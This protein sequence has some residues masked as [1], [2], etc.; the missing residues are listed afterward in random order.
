MKKLIL[1]LLFFPALLQAAPVNIRLVI[2]ESPTSMNC[3]DA[4]YYFNSARS[5]IKKHTGA[6]TRI[7]YRK[8]I[9]N[10]H[11]PAPVVDNRILL[12]RRV[13]PKLRY[14]RRTIGIAIMP[15]LQD[16]YGGL[17]LGLY[18]TEGCM[19]DSLINAEY[20]NDLGDPRIFESY[21]GMI[22]GLALSLG[23][24]FDNR[25]YRNGVSV[26]HPD[27]IFYDQTLITDKLKNQIRRCV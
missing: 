24:G 1:F 4:T 10:Y 18:N 9:K 15:P 6:R 2:V 27:S 19:S 25:Y 17:Y 21:I 5:F 3:H 7:S 16:E 12:Y 20:V 14:G 23:A 11:G 22:Q 13:S 26:M 8:C